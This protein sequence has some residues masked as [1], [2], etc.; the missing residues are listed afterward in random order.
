MEKK[1]TAKQKMIVLTCI[2]SL[3]IILTIYAISRVV[4][5][6]V[7]NPVDSYLEQEI[8]NREQQIKER[9]QVILNLYTQIRKSDSILASLE[10]KKAGIINKYYYNEKEI[11]TS[12][13]SANRVMRIINQ[14]SF[15]SDYFK[16]KYAP[17]NK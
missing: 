12:G 2:Y 1:L 4:K 8:K 13:D 10:A 16:G 3:G 6:P 15:E 7:V 9:E 5:Q 14:S 11:L 17:T